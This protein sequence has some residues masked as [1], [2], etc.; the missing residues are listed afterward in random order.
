MTEY[1]DAIASGAIAPER[2]PMDPSFQQMLAGAKQVASGA[3]DFF[4]NRVAP[5]A[6]QAA[7]SVQNAVGDRSGPTA[8]LVPKQLWLLVATAALAVIAL[9]SV[10]LPAGS[11]YGNFSV[12]LVNRGVSGTGWFA[13]VVFLLVLA[14][15]ALA[16]LGRSAKTLFLVSALTVLG[17]VVGI[18]VSIMVMTNITGY[19]DA[20]VGAGSILLLIFSAPVSWGICSPAPI[21]PRSQRESA[22]PAVRNRIK[23]D[24]PARRQTTPHHFHLPRT[25]P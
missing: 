8:S 6:S 9:I 1:Q 14:G 13:F 2:R 3:K 22:N 18:L 11:V 25:K 4:N 19:G 5:T 23:R 12:N 17:G 21:A 20:S 7:Y 16:L 15:I 24:A 10:F